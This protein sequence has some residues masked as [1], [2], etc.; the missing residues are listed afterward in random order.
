MPKQKNNE[1]ALRQHLL[2]LLNSGHAHADFNAAV[3]DFPSQLRGQKP[4]G[5]PHTAWQLLEH[6]RI[7]QWDILEF[8][9]K[10]KHVSPPW[11]EGYW[12]ATTA[13]P[14]DSAWDKSVK[15]FRADLA[16]LRRLV[17]NPKTNLHAR[18]PHGTGQ[19]MLR[20]VLLV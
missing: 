9:R 1:D 5:A 20:E 8:S 3:S 6:M 14:E 17:K 2:D 18:I 16:T 7:A 10:A 19:T 13:P 12:P 11:P 4:K 15:A